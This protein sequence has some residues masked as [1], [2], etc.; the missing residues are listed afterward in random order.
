MNKKLRGLMKGAPK[1]KSLH[2][3]NDGGKIK[4]KTKTRRKKK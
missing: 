1:V 4:G 3:I 2:A